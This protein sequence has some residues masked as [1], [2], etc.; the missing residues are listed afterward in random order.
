MKLLLLSAALL[1]LGVTAYS[2]NDFIRERNAVKRS[3]SPAY[4]APSS[5]S[6]AAVTKA[7]RELL[8][9]RETI[10][11]PSETPMVPY[12]SPNSQYA[13]FIDITAA[14]YKDRTLM[15]SKF[16]DD[17]TANSIISTLLYLR[18]ESSRD[19]ISIYLNCPGGWQRPS[20]AVYDL[21]QNTK[22][23]RAM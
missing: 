1:P 19:P 9:Q 18:K 7:Q 3:A 11:M 10:R 5:L 14:M 16:I 20:L 6:Q 15:I 22:M 23:V 17:N 12:R 4:I 13:Q 2:V 21:I 8:T